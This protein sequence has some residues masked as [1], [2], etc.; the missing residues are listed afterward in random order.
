M[1]GTG[2]SPHH[3]HMSAPRSYNCRSLE[4]HSIGI[5]PSRP[6][7]PATSRLGVS[8]GSPKAVSTP[9]TTASTDGPTPTPIRLVSNVY[10]YFRHHPRHNQPITARGVRQRLPSTTIHVSSLNRSHPNFFSSSFAHLIALFNRIFS[11]E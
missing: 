1:V 9:R 6:F 4:K 10:F 2:S 3:P 7:A 11:L 5:V 8:S